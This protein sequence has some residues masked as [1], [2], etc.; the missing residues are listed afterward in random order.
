MLRPSE[1]VNL[2][3]RDITLPSQILLS[4]SHD[5][6]I[7]IRD[8]KNRAHFGRMQF[9]KVTCRPLIAWLEWLCVDLPPSAALFPLSLQTMRSLLKVLTHEIGVSSLG[10]TLASLR[11]GGA[12]AMFMRGTHIDHLR[13][14]GRWKSVHT[15]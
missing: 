6:V 11:T 13:F 1:L 10:I 8:P 9:A 14:A 5:V 4:F 12:T 7:L 2:H 3:R 15:L